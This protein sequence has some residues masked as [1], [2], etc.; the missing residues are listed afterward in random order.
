MVDAQKQICIGNIVPH[1]SHLILERPSTGA[2]QVNAW[3]TEELLRRRS[4]GSAGSVRGETVW[5][6]TC[7]GH[8]CA[9]TVPLTVS[10]D[11]K[12]RNWIQWNQGS[13]DFIRLYLR[14]KV[15]FWKV[16]TRNIQ[17]LSALL[18][19]LLLIITISRPPHLVWAGSAS[20][21]Q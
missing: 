11:A 20:Q 4:K 5:E 1:T 7:R 16:S 19:T 8:C 9:K 2:F 15:C 17:V 21:Q 6:A 14:H 3:D 10:N 18:T 13:T 12:F